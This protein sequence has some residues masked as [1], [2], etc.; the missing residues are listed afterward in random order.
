LRFFFV[1][2]EFE[3]YMVKTQKE[4]FDEAI[5]FLLSV[6]RSRMALLSTPTR[7]QAFKLAQE[8]NITVEDLLFAHLEI[9]RN[10]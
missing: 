3:V 1:I 2:S 10:T 5:K 4:Q 6:L 7:E 8:Q 9:L